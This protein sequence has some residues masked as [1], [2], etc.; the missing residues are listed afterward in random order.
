VLV[1]EGEG[2]VGVYA[3]DGRLLQRLTPAAG[4]VTGVD[5][6]SALP[7]AFGLS[8]LVATANPTTR[9]VGLFT[10]EPQSLAL[11]SVLEEALL[12]D[13]APRAVALA[14][15]PDARRVYVF[16]AD[17]AGAVRQWE[18]VPAEAGRL[19]AQR[20]RTFSLPSG[21][22]SMVSDDPAG[23]L[24][25]AEEQN[26]LWRYD[27]DPDA[28]VSGTSVD[29]LASGRLFPPIT[30][31]TL[32]SARSGG[33]LLASSNATASIALYQRAFPHAPVGGLQLRPDGGGPSETVL[34]L[35]V[36]ALGLGTAF[37]TGVLL[38]GS[39]TAPGMRD[40]A[41][42]PWGA[43]ASAFSPALVVDPASDP[44]QLPGVDGGVQPDGGTGR[45]GGPSTG[46]VFPPGGGHGVPPETEGTGCGCRSV[47]AM[48]AMAAFAAVLGF[49]RRR[50]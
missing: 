35:D 12:A 29:S 45:D 24:F 44:R 46:G 25:V 37:P 19:E 23:T 18:L 13:I 40:V 20:V 48:G 21:V 7:P 32:Y 39:G 6:R 14:L 38:T 1:A 2:G 28:G 41:L 31:V 16:A 50:K 8:S 47:E 4:T 3:L 43:V 9:E 27:T 5:T 34:S 30:G 10:V 33:Y 36:Q 15:S 42:T 17:V 11:R 26:G 49:R 22:S